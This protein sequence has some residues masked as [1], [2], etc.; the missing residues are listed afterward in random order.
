MSI[1]TTHIFDQLESLDEDEQIEVLHWLWNK[2]ASMSDLSLDEVISLL[3]FLLVF[4][5]KQWKN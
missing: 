2:K 3:V 5:E 4:V 1:A